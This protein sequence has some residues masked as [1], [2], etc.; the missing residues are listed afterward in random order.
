MNFHSTSL[1]S[2]LITHWPAFPHDTKGLHTVSFP[3]Y[4][5]TLLFPMS[6]LIHSCDS[7]LFRVLSEQLIGFIS[8]QAISWKSTGV[9][10]NPPTW[11]SVQFHLYYLISDRICHLYCGKP[12][13]RKS[14]GAFLISLKLIDFIL[15]DNKVELNEPAHFFGNM[16]CI[17]MWHF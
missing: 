14:I 8:F 3:V 7:G 13:F 5:C 1:S 16:F 2:G 11:S 17:Q 12:I 15:E 9:S 10:W 6:V 4:R